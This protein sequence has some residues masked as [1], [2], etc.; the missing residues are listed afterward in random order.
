MEINNDAPGLGQTKWVFKHIK[1]YKPKK[2]FISLRDVD[3]GY[4]E[5]ILSE[6]ALPSI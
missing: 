6:G 2:L 5:N 4:M 1:E 3:Q